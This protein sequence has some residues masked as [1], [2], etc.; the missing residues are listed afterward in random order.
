MLIFLFLK[1]ELVPCD[2][3]ALRGTTWAAIKASFLL[4]CGQQI[5]MLHCSCPRLRWA[6]ACPAQSHV[7]LSTVRINPWDKEAALRQTS[8]MSIHTRQKPTA[9][10]DGGKGEGGSRRVWGAAAPHRLGRNCHEDTLWLTHTGINMLQPQILEPSVNESP[11]LAQHPSL[12][13]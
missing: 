7:S 11:N 13:P 3:T 5:M 8:A 9:R 4:H 10:R 12:A 2:W 1:Q 6:T